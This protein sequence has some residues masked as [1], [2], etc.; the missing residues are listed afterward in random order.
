M[1]FNPGGLL[2]AKVDKFLSPRVQIK[3]SGLTYYVDNKTSPFL[4]VKVSL[5]VH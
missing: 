4:A 5:R 1:A 3:H 2:D